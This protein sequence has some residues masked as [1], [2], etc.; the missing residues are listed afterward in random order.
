MARRRGFDDLRSQFVTSTFSSTIR[1]GFEN[2][3]VEELERPRRDERG[4]RLEDT[5]SLVDKMMVPGWDG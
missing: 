5:F 1:V 2:F 3:T 4:K